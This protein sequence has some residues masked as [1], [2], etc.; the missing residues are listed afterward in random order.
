MSEI[1]ANTSNRSGGAAW[2]FGPVA[3]SHPGVHKGHMEARLPPRRLLT[4]AAALVLLVVLTTG[5]GG[6]SSDAQA[7]AKNDPPAVKYTSSFLSFTHPAAWKASSPRTQALHFNPLVYLSTQ[8]VHAPCTTTGNETACGFPVKQLEPGGVLVSW[9]YNGGPPALTLGPGKR[10]QVG[11]RP[12]TVVSAAGG[13]CGQIGA[14]RTIDVRVEMQPLP[15]ALLE[16]T[17]CLC[18]PGLAQEEAGVNA[19]LASTKFPSQ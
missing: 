14:D 4:C 3:I 8:P 13:M 18:G 9:L 10:I 19:L 7:A 5:C 1:Q 17:A 12:A 2:S 6:G 16:L 15:S 11:G